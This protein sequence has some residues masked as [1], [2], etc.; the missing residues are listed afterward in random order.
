MMNVGVRVTPADMERDYG[1]S[2]GH[3][4]H[5]EHGMDSFFA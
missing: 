5:A 2:G 1:L 4:Y 3:L